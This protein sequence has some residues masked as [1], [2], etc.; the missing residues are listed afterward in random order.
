MQL[1][2]LDEIRHL[3]YDSSK[4]YKERTKAYHDKKI[5]KRN[6]SQGDQVLLFN[7]RLKLFPGKLKSR[8]SGPFVIKE[9]RPY[10]A[11]ELWDKSGGHFVVNG[12]RL[13]H[14]LLIP[15]SQRGNLFLSVIH[16]CLIGIQVKL[17]T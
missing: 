3:A 16:L 8:W 13:S 11:F 6:F 14:T 15:T 12:Q 17:V 5:L 2:E 4:I 7:S 9:V 10:G 1:V